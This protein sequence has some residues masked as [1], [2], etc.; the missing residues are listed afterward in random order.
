MF[1]AARELLPPG[2]DDLL[3]VAREFLNRN[4]SRSALQQMLKRRGVPTLIKLARRDAEED[5]KTKH[6]P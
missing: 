1:I 4:L 5:E 2:L 6:W 3:V